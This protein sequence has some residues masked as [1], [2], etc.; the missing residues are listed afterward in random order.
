VVEP[1]SSERPPLPA[2]SEHLVANLEAVLEAARIGPVID[3]ACGRGRH[4]IEVASRGARVVGLD[5]NAD[6][7][8][9]LS[10]RAQ[11][12]SLSL[13]CVRCDLESTH[14]LS[15]APGSCGVVLVY[16][17]LY[18]PLADA[19]QSLLAPGGLLLYETFTA[20]QRELDHGPSNPAFLLEPG[21]LP[22]LFPELEVEVYEECSRRLPRPDEIARLRA[23]R[24]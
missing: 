23:R 7:L 14:E 8:A 5:R 17:F 2:P 22:R 21:E 1:S 19:I 24:V 6:S 16:R 10:A 9:E 18:R 11:S 13:E 4:A 3:L 12:L 15:I 20:G